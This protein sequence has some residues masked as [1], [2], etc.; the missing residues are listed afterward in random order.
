MKKIVQ[1]TLCIISFFAA[2]NVSAKTIK[3]KECEYTDEYIKYQNMSPEEKKEVIVI[4]KM[5]KNKSRNKYVIVG[6]SISGVSIN[7]EKFSLVE[8]GYD[9][10]VKDQGETEACWAYSTISSIESNLLVNGQ[11]E[12]DFS[13][14]HIELATQNTINYGNTTFNREINSGGNY[15]VSSAYLLNGY[16]PVLDTYLPYSKL[17]KVIKGE[18]T[19]ESSYIN[20][21][22]P[23]V[24]VNDIVFFDFDNKCDAN[25]IKDI[26]EYLISNGA[27]STYIY[28]KN[29]INVYQ[30]YDGAAYTEDSEQ[31]PAEQASNHAITIVGWDDTISKD[32]FINSDAKPAR[33]GAWLVKNSYGTSLEFADVSAYKTDM[34]N[35]NQEE[36]NNAGINSPEEISDEAALEHISNHNYETFKYEKTQFFIKDGKF[37][38]KIG[39]D[40]YHYVSYDD[41]NI[42]YSL[43]GF[44][45]IDKI[46]ADNNYGYSN[47]G[48]NRDYEGT[49]SDTIYE[50]IIFSKKSGGN[51]KLT[52]VGL[53]FDEVG[54]QYEI[55]FSNSDN[56]K[57]G[58]LI[59]SGTSTHVG[60]TK[61]KIATSAIITN[62][63]FSI[64]VKI[65]G[66]NNIPFAAL[67]DLKDIDSTQSGDLSEVLEYYNNINLTSNVTFISVDG[68][69]F[70]DTTS[71]TSKFQLA[72]M[73]YTVNTT[74]QPVTPEEPDE[75]SDPTPGDDPVIIITPDEPDDP[76]VSDDPGYDEPADSV[77]TG[78][79]EIS[80]GIILIGIILS[81]SYIYISKRNKISNI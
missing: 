74:E 57:G 15:L 47:L 8:K 9:T 5:C 32:L 28:L 69:N 80:L 59:A 75:P 39:A 13:E 43:A 62:N 26:K 21:T 23:V 70:A 53:Y 77:F 46:I 30:Y 19:V 35:S 44:Y 52:D 48:I 67:S 38:L 76:V 78:W 68:V 14:G 55:Y 40:G 16:G 81:V 56:Y 31:I 66:N 51:E 42:C 71:G 1:I 63:K 36:Y 7:D 22:T 60:Y 3:L 6:S 17:I 2:I 72:T 45:N 41:Y 65:K 11:G 18:E 24:D 64:K 61:V 4:P 37:Y 10:S 20:N 79:I 54:Q 58:T 50:G 33:N 49:G 25:A 73:A 27:M 34:Y 12:Y 29:D